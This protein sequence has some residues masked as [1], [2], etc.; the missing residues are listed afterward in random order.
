MAFKLKPDATFVA[1]VQIPNG[2]TPL[3]LKLRFKR[4]SKSDLA[5]WVESAAGRN[6][7]D[8]IGEIIDGWEDVDADYSAAALAELLESY[9]GA[10][11]AIF[12]GYLQAHSRAERKN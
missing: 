9:S 7:K 6:D 10:A 3:P 12:S 5:A 4:K 1:T 2:D 8:S 11:M